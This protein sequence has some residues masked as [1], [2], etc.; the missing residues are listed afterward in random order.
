MHH[1]S[2]SRPAPFACP[3][4]TLMPRSLM[5]R[6]PRPSPS[7]LA[8][9][10]LARGPHPHASLP[11]ARLPRP[12]PS[13]LAPMLACPALT[14]MPRSPCLPRLPSMPRTLTSCLACPGPHPHARSLC[15]AARSPSCSMLACPGPHLMPR[16]LTAS[17]PLLT[18][19][20]SLPPPGP[21][22]HASLPDASLAPALNPHASLLMPACP[23]LHASSCLAC[24]SPS[25]LAP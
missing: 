19:H 2:R 7:C 14:L 23:A 24:P 18:P 5:P 3:A 8:H 11:D 21:H 22:P 6:L 17:A 16:S 20:A 4:L 9:A 13:C 12:S 15:L 25:C 1:A 10:S